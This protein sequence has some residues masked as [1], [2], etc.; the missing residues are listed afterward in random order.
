MNYHFE[1]NI[2]IHGT[3][4]NGLKRRRKDRKGNNCT[5]LTCRPLSVATQKRDSIHCGTHFGASSNLALK[6][7]P[8]ERT[9]ARPASFSSTRRVYRF[10]D[11]LVSNKRTS[12]R[13]DEMLRGTEQKPK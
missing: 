9:K 7:K 3:E 2:K 13:E 5:V 4:K 10:R 12:Q 11:W 6:T 8:I 1:S